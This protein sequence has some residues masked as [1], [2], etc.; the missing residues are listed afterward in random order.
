LDAVLKE[1]TQ[2]TAE[3]IIGEIQASNSP[4]NAG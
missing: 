1:E 3:I 2:I 4:E